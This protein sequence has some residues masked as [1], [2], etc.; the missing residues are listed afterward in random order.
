MRTFLLVDTQNCAMRA[1][2]A[3][4]SGVDPWTKVGLAL[5]ITLGGI[6][7]MWQKFNPDHV[8]F[9]AEGRSWR[10]DIDEAYKRNRSDARDKQSDDEKEEM[11]MFFDMVNDFIE[12]VETK[13][14][15]TLLRDEM[16][17]ADDMIAGW[18]RFHPNDHHIIL[19]TD[20][21][22]VQLL[23]TNVHIYDPV[24]EILH[25]LQGS[26]DVKGK[27]AKNKKG[28]LLPPPDPELALFLKCVKG[29]TSDNVFT[30][31]PGA[32]MKST[33]KNIGIME[34]YEDRN[35]RGYAWNNFMNQRWTH[36]DG[37]DRVVKDMYAHNQILVD[38]TRQP[39]FI[40]ERIEAMIKEAVAKPAAQMVGV[41]FLRFAYKYEL[42][43]IQNS[44]DQ[45][46]KFLSSKYEE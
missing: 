5:H 36:H 27:P 7:N 19:S 28:E 22:Y 37:K 14:N 41:Q 20:K 29:D 10:K 6:K 35:K 38:L 31:Y 33:K 26:F 17:E 44:P 46:V 32:R 8:V 9:C 12:Y 43:T 1:R 45:Y 4:H 42:N 39:D 15:A 25:T 21:D 30:A 16:C 23:D 2:H 3:A 18:I 34:A 13:T 11:K 24:A 40:K